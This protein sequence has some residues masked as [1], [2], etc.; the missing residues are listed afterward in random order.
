MMTIAVGAALAA[1]FI[2]LFI[3]LQRLLLIGA[4]SRQSAGR[5][6]YNRNRRLG[7]RLAAFVARFEK[8][9]RH[10]SDLLE[11]LRLSLRPEGFILMTALLLIT[12]VTSGA[13]LF[14][15]VKGSLLLGVVL[16]LLPYAALR[17]MLVHRQ[18][19]TQMD[20]LPAVELFYQCYLITGERHIRSALKRTVEEKR[21]LGHVQAVFEQ[22]YRNLSVRGDDETSLRIFSTS[23]G[24][25]WGDY[26]VQIMRVAL[27][28]G[29]TVTGNLKE[30]ITDMRKSRRANEQERHKLLEIRIANFTPVLFLAFFMGINFHYN[31]ANSYLYYVL[32]PQGRDMLLNAIVL[33]FA[34]FLMGLWLS[35]KKM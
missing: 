2:C 24:H 7:A 1:L 23:L 28:E 10:V 8:P 31:R 4:D 22:L 20:F 14:Q 26:L 16:G 9:H 25:I 15:S 12:G 17:S 29:H 18:L 13:I 33:I 6:N 3:A 32:D 30:L 27:A 11:S 35:R 5:L 34:S 19:Q 21:M